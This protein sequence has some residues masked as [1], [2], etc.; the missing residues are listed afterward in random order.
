MRGVHVRRDVCH[1]ERWTVLALNQPGTHRVEV[2][3][4]L[5]GNLPDAPATW[6]EIHGGQLLIG[7]DVGAFVSNMRGTTADY[8]RFAP[9]E[10]IPGPV[11][12]IQLQP[13]SKYRVVLATYSRGI[14]TY[15]FE[16]AVK[17][18]TQPNDPDEE[19]VRATRVRPMRR[20][21]R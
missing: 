18:P 17:P 8:P 6:V 5:A 7:T 13:G 4:P 14:W 11:S 15:D 12:S 19:P 16:N 9:L 1:R 3:Q 20:S 21:G 2:Q 10:N